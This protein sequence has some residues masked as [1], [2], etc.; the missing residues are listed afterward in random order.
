MTTT[1]YL[2]EPGT[3]VRYR[4]ESLV[5]MRKE[6]SQTCRLGEVDLVIVLPGGL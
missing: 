2:T 5:V 4:N 1:L 3:T 6:K